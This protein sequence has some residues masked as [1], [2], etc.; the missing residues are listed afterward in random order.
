MS[1]SKNRARKDV[2]RLLLLIERVRDSAYAKHSP[3]IPSH[4]EHQY[5]TPYAQGWYDAKGQVLNALKSIS[6]IETFAAKLARQGRTGNSYRLRHRILLALETVLKYV[7]MGH[8]QVIG[9]ERGG[10][11]A[12]L[13]SIGWNDAKEQVFA[14]LQGAEYDLREIKAEDEDGWY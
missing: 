6:H 7:R 2:E 10:E 3:A 11:G 8:D 4:D 14:V 9:L 13:Y 5:L 12:K 1:N